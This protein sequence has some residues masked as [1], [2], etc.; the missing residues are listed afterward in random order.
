MRK[1]LYRS[2]I[3][4]MPEM[5]SQDLYSMVLERAARKTTPAPKK[6]N[7]KKHCE[8]SDSNSD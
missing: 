3:E 6:R 8:S 4:D 7:K 5:N 1:E 2:I